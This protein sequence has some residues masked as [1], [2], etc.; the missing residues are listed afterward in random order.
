LV[1]WSN[2]R[3]RQETKDITVLANRFSAVSQSHDERF[4]EKDCILF[5]SI[6]VQFT[7]GYI[8][9]DCYIATI[10]K[11]VVMDAPYVSFSISCSTLK[12][13][14]ANWRDRCS[15]DL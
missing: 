12:K 8:T 7:C 1:A 5:K 2:F 14:L 13:C 9:A 10:D 15:F 6:D 11:T 4:K 3:I